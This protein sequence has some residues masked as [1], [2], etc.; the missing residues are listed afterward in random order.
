VVKDCS[1]EPVSKHITSTSTT[2]GPSGK[3]ARLNG[4]DWASAFAVRRCRGLSGREP[5]KVI[6]S[7]YTPRRGTAAGARL[8]ASTA[9][10]ST[11][12]T[13][14]TFATIESLGYAG[15]VHHG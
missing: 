12:L 7:L 14:T 2:N 1:D 3:G 5:R 8:A 4:R 13:S 10:A 9:A 11:S 15:N 6:S